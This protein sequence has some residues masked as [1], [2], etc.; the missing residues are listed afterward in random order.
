MD[1][2]LTAESSGVP[3]E[4]STFRLAI[5]AD[6]A[7]PAG[8]APPRPTRSRSPAARVLVVDDNATNRRILGDPARPLGDGRP[9][10]AAR[11]ARR[12]RWVQRRRATFDLAILDLHMPEM[13]GIALPRR[14]RRSDAGARRSRSCILSSVG[15]PRPARVDAVAAE[16]TKPVKPSALHDAVMSALGGGARPDAAPVAKA[17]AGRA[18][19]ADARPLRILLAEDNAVNQK[20]A[21]RLLERM[22]YAADVASSG[23]EAL[24]ALERDAVRRRADGRP[25]AGDGRARG[26]PP[27][28]RPLARRGRCGSSR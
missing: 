14:S 10:D 12:S 17:G 24:A 26:D 6:E 19:S 21:L 1:G 2:S 3:G 15:R 22:G 7:R 23:L 9:R 13:D 5:Q 27:D 18:A 20:L 11:R 28:P 4:G 8:A 16:L 25:D